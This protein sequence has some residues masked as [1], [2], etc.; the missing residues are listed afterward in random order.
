MARSFGVSWL[1]V[2]SFFRLVVGWK[3]DGRCRTV[4]LVV[5]RFGDDPDSCLAV[6]QQIGR[7]NPAPILHRLVIARL[8]FLVN[9]PPIT[10]NVTRQKLPGIF[11][12]LLQRR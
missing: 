5:S 1:S 11:F 7:K 8:V 9:D 6:V 4:A 3:Q 2:P 12:S 10:G